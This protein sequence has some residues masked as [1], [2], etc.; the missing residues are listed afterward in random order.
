MVDGQGSDGEHG[1]RR[2][3]FNEE[4]PVVSSAPGNAPRGH[5]RVRGELPCSA[6]AKEQQ[7][8]LPGILLFQQ[9]LLPKDAQ[10]ASG[11]LLRVRN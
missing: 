11:L 10:S 6:S 5:E 9:C 1:E 8:L 4:L 3:G 7:C 2:V